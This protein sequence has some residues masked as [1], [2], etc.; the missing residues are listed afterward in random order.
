MYSIANPRVKLTQGVVLYRGPSLIDNKEIVVISTGFNGSDNE[1]TG[2]E[3]QTWI[4]PARK[5]PLD[6]YMK[7]QD[8]S[9]CG[10]CKHSSVANGGWGTCY[11]RA[12]HAPN[13]IWNAWKNRKYEFPN[14]VNV[15]LFHESV[16]RMGSYGD[17]SAV[18]MEVWEAITRNAAGWTGYTHHWA[19]SFCDADLKRFCMASVDTLAEYHRAKARGWRCFRIR[20]DKDDP[21]QK[22]EIVCPASVEGGRKTICE[23]CKLCSGDSNASD[24][25]VAIVAHGLDW[26]VKRFRKSIKMKIAKKKVI[27]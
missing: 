23:K 21:L 19:K 6:A 4:L 10:D 25:D 14:T 15:R 20:L 16:V 24:K 5:S 3:I 26:K 18:P 22:N 9:V 1:K 17:P 27:W 12:F 8:C 2:D 7:G 11:T 13:N